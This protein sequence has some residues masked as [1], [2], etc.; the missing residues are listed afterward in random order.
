VTYPVGRSRFLVRAL[1]VLWSAGAAVTLSWAAAE[2]ALGWRLAVAAG[3]V[4]VSGLAAW[5]TWRNGAQGFLRWDGVDWRFGESR[6]GDDPTCQVTVALDFQGDLL[7]AVRPQERPDRH[8]RTPRWLWLERR[9]DPARWHA[10][11]CAVYSA[12]PTADRLRALGPDSR[13]DVK[14]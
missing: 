9:H 11:R 5:R 4:L 7:L 1:I 12:A 13:V 8:A 14:S 6:T 3:L 10:L 2:G